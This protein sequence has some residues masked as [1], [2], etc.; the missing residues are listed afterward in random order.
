MND[1]EIIALFFER[2]EAAIEETG[3]KYG[4]LLISL[5]YNVLSDRGDAEECVNDTY[6]KAW[7]T[8]PPE[9][10]EAFSAYLAK[11]VRNL[12]IDRLREK[13]SKKRS[14]S[15]FAA[16]LDELSECVGE[17]TAEEVLSAKLLSEALDRYLRDI[18]V[19]RRR[20]FILRYFFGDSLIKISRDTDLSLPKVKSMLSRER[21]RLAEYLRKE[22]FGV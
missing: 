12:A 17:N 15:R 22:G 9:K 16:C 21:Q 5:A 6:L 8:I 14:P 20:V 2:N 11:I 1:C 18:P 3:R 10:P 13:N 4:A 19:E 7:N